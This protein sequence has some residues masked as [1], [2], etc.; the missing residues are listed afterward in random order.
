MPPPG[1]GG[2]GGKVEKSGIGGSGGGVKAGCAGVSC[3]PCTTGAASGISG[4]IATNTTLDRGIVSDRNRARV[5]AW[6]DGGLSGAGLY[7]KARAVRN[8]ILARLPKTMAFQACGGIGT[9][10]QA[11]EALSD[12]AALVQVYSALI[13]EGPGLAGELNRGLAA[14]S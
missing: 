8:H 2:S 1:I 7:D 12:G 9:A 13:F 5:E 10:A 3:I 4:L 14:R 11:T 6:G